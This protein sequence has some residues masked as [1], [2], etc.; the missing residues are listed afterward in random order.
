MSS[1]LFLTFSS[2]YLDSAYLDWFPWSLW[3]WVL[4][5]LMC[6]DLFTFF[7]MQQFS[8]TSTICWRCS[9]MLNQNFWLLYQISDV[10]MCVNLCLVFNSMPLINM[11]VC[12]TILCS[13]KYCSS[14]VQFELRDGDASNSFFIMQNCFSYPVFLCIYM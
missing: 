2:V 14:I 5:M 11:S 13:F 9:N 1:K 12:M 4:W 3:S 7:Y 10:H 6:L 8:L